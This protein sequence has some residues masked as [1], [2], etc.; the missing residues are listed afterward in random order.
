VYFVRAEQRFGNGDG[1]Y[2]KSEQLRALDMLYEWAR[3]EHRF[4]G[5]PRRARIGIEVNF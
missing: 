1:V 4:T 2:D 3:G 5:P